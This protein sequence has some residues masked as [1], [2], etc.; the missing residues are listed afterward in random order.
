[1]KVT[2]I[3]WVST[4]IWIKMGISINWA[5]ILN[6]KF[7]NKYYIVS[8]KLTMFICKVYFYCAKT[9]SVFHWIKFESDFAA[10]IIGRHYRICVWYVFGCECIYVW[11]K[12]IKIIMIRRSEP[13]HNPGAAIERKCDVESINK[14]TSICG[15]RKLWRGKSLKLILIVCVLFIIGGGNYT[16]M[17][18][19]IAVH[20]TGREKEGVR[21]REK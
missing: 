7:R 15:W 4:T 19:K 21:E 1:M 11:R 8:T 20:K 12:S 16:H 3:K 9:S 10:S 18:H 14:L 6:I 13:P 2:T 17:G 5:R